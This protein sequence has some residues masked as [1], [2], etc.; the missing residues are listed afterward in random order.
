LEREQLETLADVIASRLQEARDDRAPEERKQ[1]LTARQTAELLAVDLKTVYRHARELGGRKVGGAWRFDLHAANLD[2]AGEESARYASERPHPPKP[3]AVSRRRRD[4][5]R[6]RDRVD[7]QLL[8]VGR[9]SDRGL[10]Q[11]RGQRS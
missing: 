8:P 9:V 2:V 5:D 10:Q 11:P 6:A 3:P 7:C 1:L 4:R